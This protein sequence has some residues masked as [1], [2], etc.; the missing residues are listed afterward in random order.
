VL[1]LYHPH[2]VNMESIRYMCHV[3]NSTIAAVTQD[4][5][6]LVIDERETLRRCVCCVC[7]QFQFSCFIQCVQSVNSIVA[8]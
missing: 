7:I 2:G 4:A 8:R 3:N 1:Q 5:E 6:L